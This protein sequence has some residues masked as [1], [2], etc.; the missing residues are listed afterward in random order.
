MV[1][2]RTGPRLELECSTGSLGLREPCRRFV[3]R[4]RP[5]RGSQERPRTRRGE[6]EDRAPSVVLERQRLALDGVPSEPGQ[7]RLI[8]G[9]PIASLAV[10]M[11]LVLGRLKA[12]RQ[13]WPSADYDGRAMT[14]ILITRGGRGLGRATA[15][16]LAA[17][18]H[19]VSEVRACDRGRQRQRRQ[20]AV[21]AGRAASHALRDAARC[22]SGRA[23]PHGCRP[24][25]RGC[26]GAV[27]RPGPAHRTAPPR[28]TCL[29]CARP[30]AA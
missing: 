4:D 9:A 12:R 28:S 14:T 22:C 7:A 2:S 1:R 26:C 25:H 21:H 29:T 3:E 23:R 20:A 27:L 15:K 11:V 17:A 5:P 13:P 16:K 10:G 19:R 8:H 30:V 18:G 24:V 6:D